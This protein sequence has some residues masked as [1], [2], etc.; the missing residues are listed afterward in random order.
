M[1]QL[2]VDVIALLDSIASDKSLFFLSII[3]ESSCGAALTVGRSLLCG[4]TARVQMKGFG[5]RRAYVLWSP[6]I[7]FH[8]RLLEQWS[9]NFL[10]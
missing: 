1:L 10:Q 2:A 4:R 8:V 6:T 5:F 3:K 7:S 9:L